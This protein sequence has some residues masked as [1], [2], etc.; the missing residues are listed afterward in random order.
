MKR[1]QTV[2]SR[3]QAA[4]TWPV[5]APLSATAWARTHTHRADRVP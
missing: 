2:P 1:D 5:K 4:V 3:R